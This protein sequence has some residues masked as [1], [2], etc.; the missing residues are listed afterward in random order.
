[1]G[2]RDVNSNSR[3]VN[4]RGPVFLSYRHSDGAELATNLAWALRSAGMPVWHDQ[5]DLPPGDTE[6]RLDDAMQSGLSGAVLLVTPDTEVSDCIKEVELPRLLALEEQ[7]SFT[8]SIASTI[9][10]RPGRLDYGAPD[11][12]LSQPAQILR[13]FHQDPALTSDDLAQ[14]ALNHCR[15]RMEALKEEIKLADQ[16]IEISLQTRFSPSST[17]LLGDLVMRLRPPPPKNRRPNRQGL[18][19]LRLALSSLPYLLQIAGA[20]HV[21]FHGG[22]HL[23]VAFALGAA[24][25]TPLLRR[26][27]VVDNDEHT[28]GL[29]KSTPAPTTATQLLEVTD[30]SSHATI[31]GDALVYVDLVPTRSDGAFEKF[32]TENPSRFAKVY[33]IRAA[34]GGILRPKDASVIVAEASNAIRQAASLSGTSEV[35]LLLRCPWPVA[36]L[37]GRTLNT[38]R[39]NL[40]EWE[41]GPDA[42]GNSEEP[43]YLPSMVVRSGAGGSPIEKVALPTRCEALA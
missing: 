38:V 29:S 30:R 6:R 15:Q 31:T 23:S 25:P 14:I 36:L 13:K 43:R 2:R 26:V 37:L 32:L 11:R 4:P 18:E 5:S 42:D 20:R 9:E 17:D 35:H 34:T 3:S 16:T 40:Y 24:L 7:G 12:L 1:M 10:K 27:D 39:V 22:A 21:R 28:W 8:L 19:E 33:H 41:T